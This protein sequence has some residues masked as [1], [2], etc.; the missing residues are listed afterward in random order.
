MIKFWVLN[1]TAQKKANKQ[2]APFK[3]KCTPKTK[4]EI[5]V[6]GYHSKV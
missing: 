5:V 1:G 3:T 4:K 2:Q 6:V